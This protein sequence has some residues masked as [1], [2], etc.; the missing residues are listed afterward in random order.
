MAEDWIKMR[1]HLYSDPKVSLMADLV[2]SADGELARYVSQHNQCDMSITRN[3]TRNATV[4][5]L[6]AVWGVFRKQ[7]VRNGDD[8]TVKPCDICAIDDIANLPGFG[9]AMCDVGW[10]IKTP[11]GVVFPR[12]YAEH[13]VD[14]REAAA[15]RQRE[16][17]ER[18]K[19]SNARNVT[20]YDRE[21]KR[22][23]KGSSGG[24]CE[25]FDA[26]S[27]VEMQAVADEWNMLG[28]P[29]G[30][31]RKVHDRRRKSLKARLADDDWRA[32][33]REAL[34]R[35]KRLK[36]CRG[37]GDRGWVATFD[38]FIKPNTVTEILE[39]KYDDRQS[40]AAAGGNRRETPGQARERANV[41]AFREFL[42]DEPVQQGIV[43]EVDGGARR[44]EANGGIHAGGTEGVARGAGDVPF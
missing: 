2:F 30:L 25:K 26:I 5:A 29:F 9:R 28:L 44:I 13:N 41:A 36:F 14:P 21:E 3:V 32:N 33:W 6:V 43:L 37:G 34:A 42:A 1:T 7:G 8:L 17:R 31:A 27:T 22:R 23:D 40:T 19:D 20:R 10:C 24:S 35:V 12:F 39:G 4:G 18:K 38:W 11:Q 15:R 16:Y